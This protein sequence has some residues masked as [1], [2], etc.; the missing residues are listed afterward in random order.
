M[1]MEAEK[2]SLKIVREFSASPETV[3]D[4]F[5]KPEAM[6]VWWT[7]QT[8]FDIDL[9]VGGH[10]TIVRKEKDMT[11]TAIG[12]YLEVERP[13]RLRYTYEMPQFSPN[14]DVITIDI[15]PDEKGGSIMTFMEDGPDIA[16]ELVSVKSGDMSESEKEWRRGFDL[17]EA[18]WKDDG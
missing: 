12:K 2:M 7:D 18:S 3:F 17:M 8:T 1:D 4:V 13:R 11:Y 5:T 6:R 15:E 9:R 10:W 16:E 14:A